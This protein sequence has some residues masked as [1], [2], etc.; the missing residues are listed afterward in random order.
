VRAGGLVVRTAGRAGMLAVGRGMGAL[1]WRVALCR[2]G[3]VRPGAGW[4]ASLRPDGALMLRRAILSS[5]SRILSIGF[6][7]LA[8]GLPA[9]QDRPDVAPLALVL[10]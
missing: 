3:E 7:S 9:L 10:L 6:A 2:A 8:I 1:P 5:R 4:E